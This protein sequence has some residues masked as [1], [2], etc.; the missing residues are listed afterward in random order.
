MSV[1]EKLGAKIEELK[2]AGTTYWL[3]PVDQNLLIGLPASRLVIRERGYN[4]L[5]PG[6]LELPREGEIPLLLWKGAY[7]NWGLYLKP[8]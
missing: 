2:N 5:V 3:E 6:G 4:I 8:S 7:L 1:L